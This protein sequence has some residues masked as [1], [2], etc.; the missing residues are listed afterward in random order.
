ML[1]ATGI[2]EFRLLRR[3]QAD[4]AKA[5]AVAKTNVVTTSTGLIRSVVAESEDASLLRVLLLL[6]DIVC[7]CS[8]QEA[9]F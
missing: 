9:G 2:A 6:E 1:F 4:A 8:G 3:N 7:A 5:N